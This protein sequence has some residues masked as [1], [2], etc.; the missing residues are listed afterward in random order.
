[1]R[2]K[3]LG[4]PAAIVFFACLVVVMSSLTQQF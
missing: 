1:M 4:F 3:G 2:K